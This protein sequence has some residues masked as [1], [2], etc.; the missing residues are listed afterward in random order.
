MWGV[1][2]REESD[3]AGTVASRL[4]E[5]ELER[6]VDMEYWLSLHG[7]WHSQL[8]RWGGGKEGEERALGIVPLT[9]LI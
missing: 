5:L 7:K 1:Q 6:W 9:I 4:Y 8:W 3:L 2:R